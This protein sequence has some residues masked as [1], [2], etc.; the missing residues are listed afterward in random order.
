MDSTNIITFNNQYYS[1]NPSTA[2]YILA[3]ENK[4]NKFSIFANYNNNILTSILVSI[5]KDESYELNSGGTVSSKLILY[6]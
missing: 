3:K 4:N 1:F 2:T 5:N 6:L